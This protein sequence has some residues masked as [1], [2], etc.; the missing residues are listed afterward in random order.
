MNTMHRKGHEFGLWRN[1][2]KGQP[3]LGWG[4]GDTAMSG[5]MGNRRVPNR[6]LYIE[7][8]RTRAEEGH[9]K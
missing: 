8:M 9:V 4:R 5:S 6:S 1:W 2:G 7:L 3:E